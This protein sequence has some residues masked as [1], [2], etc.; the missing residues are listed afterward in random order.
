MDDKHHLFNPKISDAA[1]EGRL[2]LPKINYFLKI[3]R[4]NGRITFTDPGGNLIFSGE[5]RKSTGNKF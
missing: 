4:I 5:C 2:T 1:L 3:S